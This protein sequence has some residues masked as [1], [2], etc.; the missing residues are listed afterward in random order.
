MKDQRESR[1]Y[2]TPMVLL[3]IRDN[4]LPEPAAT[5]TVMRRSPGLLPRAQRRDTI[6]A[7]GNCIY[8]MV[9]MRAQNVK[10]LL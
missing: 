3:G 7:D 6:L 5:R 8:S 9:N 10:L 4:E 1:V 2:S